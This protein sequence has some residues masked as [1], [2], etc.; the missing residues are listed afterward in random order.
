[1]FLGSFLGCCHLIL[2]DLLR[3]NVFDGRTVRQLK[4]QAAR[5]SLV[6]YFTKGF[7]FMFS[8]ISFNDY[9]CQIENR[10]PSAPVWAKHENM[11]YCEGYSALVSEKK[12]VNLGKVLMTLILSIVK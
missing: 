8:N 5:N 3:Y 12:S 9:R 6:P 11:A 4:I 10:L 2:Q 1:M 7:D